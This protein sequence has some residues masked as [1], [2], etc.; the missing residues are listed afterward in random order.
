MFNIKSKLFYALVIA[1]KCLRMG[2]SLFHM[3]K[4]DPLM[5]FPSASF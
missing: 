5:R 1:V 2:D 3:S 4:D